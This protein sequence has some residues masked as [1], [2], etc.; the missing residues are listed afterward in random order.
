MASVIVVVKR[1]ATT[2]LT[3]KKFWKILGGI[4]L[5]VLFII[6][7]PFL[8]LI[9]ILHSGESEEGGAEY[10]VQSLIETR[11]EEQQELVEEIDSTMTEAGYTAEQIEQAKTVYLLVLYDKDE[12]DVI[13]RLVGCFENEQTDESLIEALNAEFDE[14]ITLEE[15]EEIMEMRNG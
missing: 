5:G 6:V 1:V 15:W 7:A 14:N 9:A 4:V 3:N 8:A 13:E 12:E 10:Y 11:T 2:L